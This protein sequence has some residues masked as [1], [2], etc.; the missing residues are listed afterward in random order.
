RL[1]IAWS[2]LSLL[3][4]P[5]R[6]QRMTVCFVPN[7]GLPAPPTGPSAT[8]LDRIGVTEVVGNLF[9]G[10]LSRLMFFG[11]SNCGRRI[12]FGLVGFTNPPVP[13]TG[14]RPVEPL[15]VEPLPRFPIGS[16]TGRTSPPPVTGP[17]M[18]GLGSIGIFGVPRMQRWNSAPLSFAQGSLFTTIGGFGSGRGATHSLPTRT[19]PPWP[20][21]GRRH[22][23]SS[24]TV[25]LETHGVVDS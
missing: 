19:R 12:T 24:N 22:R 1:R 11:P 20:G 13:P 23:P 4:F 9:D 5:E 8:G 16:P 2:L 17:L 18:G 6:A 10:P 21:V 15:P 3:S 7:V 14:M 25:P